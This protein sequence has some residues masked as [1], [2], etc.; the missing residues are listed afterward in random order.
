MQD[1]TNVLNGQ[2]NVRDSHNAGGFDER[3]LISI[4]QRDCF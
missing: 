3:S 4:L 1:S 2:Y